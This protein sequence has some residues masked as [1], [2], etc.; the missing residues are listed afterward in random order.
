M[1]NLREGVHGHVVAAEYGRIIWFGGVQ[2]PSWT[3]M[4]ASKTVNCVVVLRLQICLAACVVLSIILTATH[5]EKNL[6]VST[7][8]E[9]MPEATIICCDCTEYMR[10]GDFISARGHCCAMRNCIP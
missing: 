4:A 5:L 2:C 8:F 6:L 10:N 7:I 9:T 3:K 1:H